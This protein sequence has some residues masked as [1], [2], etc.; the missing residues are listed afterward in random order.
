MMPSH[1]YHQPALTV[2]KLKLGSFASSQKRS[3]ARF[4]RGAV[5]SERGERSREAGRRFSAAAGYAR[6][7]PL[8][9]RVPVVKELEPMQRERTIVKVENRGYGTPIVPVIKKYGNI[10]ICGDYK[11]TTNPRLKRDPCPLAHIEQIFAA[12]SDG[13][14]F[15]KIDLANAYQQVGLDKES[16]AHTAVS[17]HVGTFRYNRTP[18]GFEL[19]TREILKNDRKYFSGTPG[20]TVLLDDICFTGRDM[21]EHIDNLRT[22]PTRLQNAGLRIELS[23]QRVLAHYDLRMLLVLSVD[24]SAYGPGDV[25]ARRYPDGS[26]RAVCYPSRSLNDAE[27]SYSLDIKRR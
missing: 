4:Y 22:V 12:L 15:S 2:N 14:L 9:L 3:A 16:Q 17:T 21:D 7:L 23:N 18:F 13:K 8:A 10:C 6:P 26:E 19:Y 25:L 11:I 1:N 20:T 24:S 27:K 5:S